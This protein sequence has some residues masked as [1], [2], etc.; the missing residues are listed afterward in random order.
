MYLVGGRGGGG[1][2]IVVS[3]N[4]WFKRFKHCLM[5]LYLVSCI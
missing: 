1:L 5:T 3:F 2:K 4:S